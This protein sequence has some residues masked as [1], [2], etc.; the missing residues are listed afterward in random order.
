MKKTSFLIVGKHAVIEALKNPNRKVLKIF[1][2]EDSKKTINRD[3]QNLN[4]LEKKKT[5][6]YFHGILPVKVIY[7]IRN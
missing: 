5:L 1:L 3:N 4:L 6:L 7:F 2:T